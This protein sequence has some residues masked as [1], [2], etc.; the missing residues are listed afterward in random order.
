ME[1]SSSELCQIGDFFKKYDLQISQ[2]IP[3]KESAEYCACNFKIND[4]NIKFRKSK[5]TPTKVG[6]FVTVW[7]RIENGTIAPFENTDFID[8]LIVCSK[9]GDNFGYFIFPKKVL[10]QKGIFTDIKEG[11]RAF[12]VYPPWDIAV[13]NQ[14]VKTQRWQLEYFYNFG[15]DSENSKLLSYFDFKK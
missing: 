11:K 5:I 3:E 6:Q 12:R 8:F 10:V 4:F 7:K 14:A 1:E 13:N 15:E 9:N 2:I